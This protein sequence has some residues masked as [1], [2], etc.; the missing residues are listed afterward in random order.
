MG[1]W[2]NQTAVVLASG[3]SAAAAQVELAR[4]RARI[5]VINESWRL[6]PWADALFATDATWWDRRGGCPEFK[7]RKFCA[8]ANA[9]KAWQLEVFV[10]PGPTSGL[11]GIFLA[12][13]L[14]ANPILLLGFEHHVRNGVH[15]HPPHQGRNPGKPEMVFWRHEIERMGPGFA[16]RG[17]KVINCTPD[18]ALKCFPFLPFLEAINGGHSPR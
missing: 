5:L 10:S 4:D 13:K 1:D 7:G 14:G 15:W 9:A 3:P 8:S 17:T 16:K 6:A 2:E 12:E 11:R 18:S